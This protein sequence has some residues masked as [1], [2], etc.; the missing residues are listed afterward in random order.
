MAVFL[1]SVEPLA[2]VG[3]PQGR[4]DFGVPVSVALYVEALSAFE[5]S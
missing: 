5:G 3:V 2:G 4:E 1:G